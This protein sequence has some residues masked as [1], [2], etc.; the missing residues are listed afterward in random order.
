MDVFQ[1]DK[2]IMMFFT[3]AASYLNILDFFCNPKRPLLRLCSEL[4]YIK[5]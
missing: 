3:N 1:I 2:S 4:R 5:L